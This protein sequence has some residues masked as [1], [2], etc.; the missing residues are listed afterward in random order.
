MSTIAFSKR[1]SADIY[2]E[3]VNDWLT[4]SAMAENYGRTEKD[5]TE[6]IDKGRIEH[7]KNVIQNDNWDIAKKDFFDTHKSIGTYITVF[8]YLQSKY[9]ISIK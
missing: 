8:D 3:W 6:I 5:M 2:L 1:T 4:I 7:E 9:T